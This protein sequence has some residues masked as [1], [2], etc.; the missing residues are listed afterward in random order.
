MRPMPASLVLLLATALASASPDPGTRSVE[1][2]RDRSGVPH[3]YA[4]DPRALF[5]G[6]GY[7]LAQDRLAQW[8]LA[9]R[10]ARGRLAEI[11]GADSLEADKAARLRDHAD[12]EW[13]RIVDGHPA[14]HRTVLLAY[15]DG[16]NRYIEEANRDPARKLPYEFGRWKVRPE[17]WTTADLAATVAQSFVYYG[18]GTHSVELENKA[19]L[20]ALHERYPA[21]VARDLFEDV[22]PLADADAVPVARAGDRQ[23]AAAAPPVRVLVP[24][25]MG[26]SVLEEAAT[27]A[28]ADAERRRMA[29]ATR[30]AS[31]ALVI[32]PGRSASGRVLMLQST[33][34]GP[35]VHLVG[36]GFDTAGW[37]F[38]ACPVPIMGRGPTFGWLITTGEEDMVDLF[39]VRTDPANPAR[40]RHRDAWVPFVSRT[41]RIRVRDAADV[42]LEVRQTVHG[43]VVIE[44][45]ATGRAYA[46]RNAL[47]HRELDAFVALVDIARSHSLEDFRRA[48]AGMRAS[49]NVLYGGEDGTIAFWHAGATPLRAAGVD[50]R[51]PTPGDGDHEWTGE[52]TMDSWPWAIDPREGYL[53][54]WNNKAH[55]ASR[56]GEAARY[57]AT[58][59]TWLGRELVESRAK[60][61]IDGLKQIN[62]ALGRSAA[63]VDLSLTSPRFFTPYLERPAA[64][65]AALAQLVR[66]MAAWNGLYEDRD[67]DGRYDDPGLG[68][69]REWNAVAQRLLVEPVIGDWWHRID[70]D[71]YI[72]Y[73]TEL[74]YRI[75]AGEDARTPLRYPWLP[76]ADRDRVLRETLRQTRAALEQRFGSTDP[77][78]WRT[79]VYWKHLDGAARSDFPAREP[80]PGDTDDHTR[81][82]AELGLQPRTI[83]H[84][85]S[86]Y[87]NAVMEIGAS[88]RAFE[89]AS[90]SGGQSQF[91]DLDGRAGRH[92]SD[93]L[94]LHRDFRFKHFPMSLEE[95]AASAQSVHRLEVP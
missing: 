24:V 50:P 23:P 73:R 57:G 43:P 4:S 68:I 9:R 88:T 53:H 86:E 45:R 32:G 76:A 85:G 49:F 91:I 28:R 44:D 89:D 52:S 62:E 48:V 55:A 59:R 42:L 31:R 67:A 77:D 27:L 22:L 46:E 90:P 51:L 94:E 14:F 13:E 64:G 30:G 95:V 15:R 2:V 19:F 80:F 35:G 79:P 41:E 16:L 18:A 38:A 12:G 54:A 21:P 60:I 56:Y 66:R 83:L 71:R 69:F 25:P 29:G 72:K 70:D 82:A 65:D 58:F 10:S 61:D 5:H 75:V 34:D 7:A 93:Q 74:L 26:P 40:Y 37:T 47:R 33:A 87:W 81:T 84:N 63:G 20:Q 17:P 3:V 8:E 78:A 6:A 11:H 1:I 39:E 36:A 92:I